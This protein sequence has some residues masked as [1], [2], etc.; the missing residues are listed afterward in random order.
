MLDVFVM[1]IV[2]MLVGNVLHND[3]Q[4]SAL[5][6][7]VL[8]LLPVH[9]HHQARQEDRV[10]PR[11]LLF[12]NKSYQFIIERIIFSI[13]PLNSSPVQSE[14]FDFWLIHIYTG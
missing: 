1:Y 5:P 2:C 8:Q 12:N 10:I 13:A 14:S 3:E 6:H 9:L 4:R 7:P 11:S